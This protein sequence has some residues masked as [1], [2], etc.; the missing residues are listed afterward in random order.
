MSQAPAGARAQRRAPRP[1]ARAPAPHDLTRPARRCKRAIAK[2]RVN[3]V[4]ELPSTKTN[5][6][7]LTLFQAPIAPTTF[8]D[9]E[10]S[11]GNAVAHSGAC[12]VP[13]NGPTRFNLHFDGPSDVLPPIQFSC[14]PSNRPTA[15]QRP[16]KS[17]QP[18]SPLEVPSACAGMRCRRERAPEHQLAVRVSPMPPV[19]TASPQQSGP[20]PGR[21]GAR[22]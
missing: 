21:G 16:C 20:H 6:N 9:C 2:D 17:F 5:Y 4:F 3:C 11:L 19:R 1:A 14:A 13:Y 22:A 18:E 10:I 8:V 15:Q 12:F 7:L